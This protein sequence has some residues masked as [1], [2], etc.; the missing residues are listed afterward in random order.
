M[1]KYIFL[2]TVV[3]ILPLFSLNVSAEEV[4]KEYFSDF[5][6]ILPDWLSGITE[7]SDR[8]LETVGIRGVVSEII[9]A[10]MGERGRILSFLLMLVG[11]V[12]LITLA[13]T[14]GGKI[15]EATSSSVGVIC[16][17]LIFGVLSDAF[18]D[19]TSS[20]EELNV[21]FNSLIPITAAITAV[22]GGA[23]SAAVGAGG[24]YL[25][26]QLV[27]SFGQRLLSSFA[28]LGLGISLLSSV[29]GSVISSVARGV[30]S[31]FFWVLGIFTAIIGAGFS[32]QTVVASAKDS[33][34]MRAA[35]YMAT[36]LVPIVGSTVSGALSTL[37]SG[38]SYAK[39]IIGTG[40]I[41]AII[42]MVLSP[43][44]LLLLY[45]LSLSV[46]GILSDFTGS[47][48]GRIFDSFR[49]SLDMMIALYALSAMIYIFEIILFMKMG[50]AIL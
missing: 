38:L 40:A 22:G 32:L 8:L 25:T 29:G 41:I 50:V 15:G 12:A 36:G 6:K 39:G 24:M 2:L 16:S 28:A 1:K 44:A 46:G 9:S 13:G 35:K 43:L 17:V 20:I 47:S 45:R 23:Q 30:R 3:V 18:E 49:F 26:V 31:L 48:A 14:M 5:E 42:G 10:V 11:C 33:M 21:F 37:A 19:I 27:S 4:T 34:S 7:D